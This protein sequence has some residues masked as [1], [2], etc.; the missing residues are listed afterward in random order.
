MFYLFWQEL[1]G[2]GYQEIGPGHGGR[3]HKI[4]A[5]GLGSPQVKIGIKKILLNNNTIKKS[6]S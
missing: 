1:Q 3:N 4:P 5:K 2:G 6:F